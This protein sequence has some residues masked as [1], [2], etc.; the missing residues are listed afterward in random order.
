MF[1]KLEF[2]IERSSKGI[3]TSHTVFLEAF[4]NFGRKIFLNH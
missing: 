1:F 2:V 4:C 3:L